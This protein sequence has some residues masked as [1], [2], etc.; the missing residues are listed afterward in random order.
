MAMLKRKRHVSGHVELMM[1]PMIDIVFQ[2][3]IFLMIMPSSTDT[4]G[5]LPTNLPDQGSTSAAP[6]PKVDIT[7]RIDLLHREP[8]NETTRNEAN[9]VLNQREITDY[10][11]LRRTLREARIKLQSGPGG[12]AAVKKTPVLISPDM[13]VVH[14][15]VVAAF[16]CA[17]D[18]GFKN[19]Q[20]SVPK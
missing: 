1:T 17:V 11:E 12:E 15:H 10:A 7:Y 9:I 2:L 6:S 20:F 19:I 13:V 16:D 4:E 5:Y 18:A 3:L 14:K 8:Y